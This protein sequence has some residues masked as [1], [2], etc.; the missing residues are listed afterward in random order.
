MQIDGRPAGETTAEYT[1]FEHL[2]PGLHRIIIIMP[3]GQRW[4][5]DIELPAGPHQVRVCSLRTS[6]TAGRFTSEGAS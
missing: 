1:A 6:H 4:S 3:D 2:D 5:R